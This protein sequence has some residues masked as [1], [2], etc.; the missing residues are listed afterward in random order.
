LDKQAIQQTVELPVMTELI[1]KDHATETYIIKDTTQYR[2]KIGAYAHL[3]IYVLIKEQ[4]AQIRFECELREHARLD[5]KGMYQLKDKQRVD[6]TT[7]QHHKGPSSSSFILFKGMVYDH[8]RADYKGTIIID[9][10]ASESH[11]EQYNKNILMSE[12][13]HAT[14]IPSLEVLTDNVRCKHGAAVGQLS[15]DHLFYL[16]SHGIELEQAK[17]LLID[18]FFA[19]VVEDMKK[20]SGSNIRQMS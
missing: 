20:E 15:Q 14:S 17:S 5:I 7:V 10:K 18:A 13:A 4:D 11:A 1:V 3:R 9:E 16:Q 6:I 8:A 19:E 2:I 12:Y